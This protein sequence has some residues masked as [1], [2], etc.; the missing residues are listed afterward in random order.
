[1]AYL[2]RSEL[3]ENLLKVGVRCATAFRLKVNRR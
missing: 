1:M 2:G 3:R